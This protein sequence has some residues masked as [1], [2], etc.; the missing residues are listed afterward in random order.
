ME[1]KRNE[2]GKRRCFGLR[3]QH[4]RR[5][6]SDPKQSEGEESIMQEK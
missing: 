2:N 3:S 1:K 5:C 6:H 4:D